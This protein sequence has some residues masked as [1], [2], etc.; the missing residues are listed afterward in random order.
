MSQPLRIVSLLDFPLSEAIAAQPLVSDPALVWRGKAG[1]SPM[2]CPHAVP[3]LWR[4][5][6]RHDVV[7]GLEQSS[8]AADLAPITTPALPTR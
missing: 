2:S 7:G 6:P 1:S 3:S 5:R 8:D 4:I